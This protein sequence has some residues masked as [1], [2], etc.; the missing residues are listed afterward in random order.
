MVARLAPQLSR[1]GVRRLVDDGAVFVDGKRVLVCARPQKPG[2]VIEL[3]LP[4]E[5]TAARDAAAA[6]R[7]LACD[8]D[9]VVVDKAGGV[10]TEPTREGSRGTLKAALADALR[11]EGKDTLFLHAAHRLDTHTTGV[12]IFARNSD[13]AHRVGRQL[14]E[15]SVERR[16]LALVAGQPAFTRARLDWSLTKS[17]DADGKIKVDPQGAPSV[18]LTTILARGTSGALALCSPRTGRTHQLRV[19]L[20]TAGHALVGDRTYGG[21][22]AKHLGLH[23]L[24]LALVHPS[25]AAVRYAAMPPDTFL[26]A[27]ADAGVPASVVVAVARCLAPDLAPDLAPEL[28]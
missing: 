17:R 14:Q 20:A 26:E 16:Y 24:S 12:V 23:A 10:P 11:R 1:R 4:D 28:A 15:G 3:A 2:A 21:G 7:I 27:A 22:R 5:S 18:T 13:A 19:H 9:L 6:P 8:D 25:G